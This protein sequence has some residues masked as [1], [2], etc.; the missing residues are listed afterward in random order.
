[1]FA[2]SIASLLRQFLEINCFQRNRRELCYLFCK[3]YKASGG[4]V[5]PRMWRRV[6][7]G[8]VRDGQDLKCLDR[9]ES[10]LWGCGVTDAYLPLH[11]YVNPYT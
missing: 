5:S 1:M 6:K 10:W 4:F 3:Q 11:P 2:L 9:K 8:V 7:E